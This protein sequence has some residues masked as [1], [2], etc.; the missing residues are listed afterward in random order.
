MFQGNGTSPY[1]TVNQYSEISADGWTPVD[2]TVFRS[3]SCSEAENFYTDSTVSKS[4][5]ASS[6]VLDEATVH[7][8]HCFKRMYAD[9]L[10]RW[11]LIYKKTEVIFMRMETVPVFTI[12][13]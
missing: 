9:I 5:K 7:L 10:H 2:V 6:C 4:E 1:S 12:P 3:N 11:Q 13:I 8:Y